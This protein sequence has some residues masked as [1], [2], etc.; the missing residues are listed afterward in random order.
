VEDSQEMP[1]RLTRDVCPGSA[2][3]MKVNADF[4]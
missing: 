2:C 3:E 1:G 4:S